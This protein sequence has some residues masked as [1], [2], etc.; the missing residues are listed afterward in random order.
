VTAAVVARGA[1]YRPVPEYDSPKTPGWQI[2]RAILRD[3]IKTSAV[4]VLIVPLPM[5]TFIDRSSDPSG[6]Q[7]RFGEL[8]G[9]TGARIY[10]PLA[11]LWALPVED[12][13]SFWSVSIGH[14]SARGHEVLASLLAPVVAE[15]VGQR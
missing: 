2:L 5:W 15:L 13:Q 7:A 4:P 9:E 11:D 3:W 12:Q 1:A 10:D 8:A 14:Y 6:I